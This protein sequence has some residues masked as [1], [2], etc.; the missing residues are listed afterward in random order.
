MK[1]S[2]DGKPRYFYDQSGV[3]PFRKKGDRLKILLVTTA[4]GKGWIVPKG[5]VE[6]GLSA[7]RSAEKEALEEAGVRGRLSKQP[8][9]V[10]TYSKWGGTC[11]VQ[12]FLLEVREVLDRWPEASIRKRRWVRV[13]EAERL[14]E[15]PGLKALVRSL[16]DGAAP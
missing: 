13:E 8:L 4:R 6:P 12:V 1:K 9:G 16:R 10:Y 14:L 5:I 15:P 11:T 2:G 7:R 3:I